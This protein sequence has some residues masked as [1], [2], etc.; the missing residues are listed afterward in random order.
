MSELLRE[1]RGLRLPEEFEYPPEFCRTVVFGLVDLEPWVMLRA[2]AVRWHADGLSS[3]Y[4][5]SSY[6][7]FARR[8][9]NDD[10]ACWEVPDRTV[11]IIHDFASPGWERR[12]RFDGFDDWLRL[13]VEDFIEWGRE[14]IV[15]HGESA[16]AYPWS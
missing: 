8:R 2:A 5:G 6:W 13:A 1:L 12:R 16:T 11:I 14:E 9:D 7:P 10:I 4:A 3:R 15:G